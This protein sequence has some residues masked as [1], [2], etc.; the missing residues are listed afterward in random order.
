MKKPLFIVLEGGEGSGKSTL[1][2][3]AKEVFGDSLVVTREPGG[4]VFGEVIRSL[5]LNH[6][7]AK[8]ASAETMLCLMFAA[9]FDHVDKVVIPALQAG[10]H[11]ISDRFDASSFAYQIY[12]QENRELVNLFNV[13]RSRINR[14]PDHYTYADV[15]VKEG[16]KRAAT[17][18]SAGNEGNHF[19]DRKVDFHERLRD[20][21]A[22]F[23]SRTPNFVVNANQGL[24]KVKADFVDLLKG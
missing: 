5:A 11:V 12:A 13:L 23:F 6:E 17:R 8:H 16:L 14:L 24:E 9:R 2:K 1:I 15:D 18:N 4:S 19:D 7:E 21:Y 22:D 10:K 20:G 3:T